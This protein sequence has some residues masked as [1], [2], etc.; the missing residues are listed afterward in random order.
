MDRWLPGQTRRF[1]R[2]AIG[3]DRPNPLL[4]SDHVM[5]D[6]ADAKKA[7]KAGVYKV[8]I[9]GVETHMRFKEGAI[10]PEG[11]E[12]RD[13]GDPIE[14]PLQQSQEK[15]KQAADER[16]KTAE[17]QRAKGPAPENRALGKAPEKQ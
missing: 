15:L 17:D 6:A 11:A 3:D 13:E 9:D 4:R 1:G 2:A 10:L 5:S 12:Y 7:D 16:A 8:T 14:S